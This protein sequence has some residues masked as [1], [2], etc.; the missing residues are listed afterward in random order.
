MRSWRKIRTAAS[1]CGFVALLAGIAVA[2]TN[3]TAYRASVEKWRAHR[4]ASLKSDD[5]WLTVA[6][7]FWL[8][9]G[10]NNFGTDALDDMVLPAGSAPAQAGTFEFHAGKT[11]VHANKAAQLMIQGKNADGA[12]LRADQDPK[13]DG[14]VDQVTLGVLTFYVH[15][16]G[17]RYAIRMQDKNNALRKR[18]TGLRW[19]PIDP[20]YRVEARYV[21]YDKPKVVQIQNMMGDFGP[22][23]IPG[24]VEFELHGQKLRLDVDIDGLELSIVF[25]DL[26]S[27]KETYGAAR[28]LVADAPKDGKAVLDFNEAYNPPCAYNPY[29]TCPL[30]TPANRLRVP[31]APGEMTYHGP[32]DP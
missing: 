2:A 29:T 15:Q 22:D 6:G 16:S 23:S 13:F 30:P 21:P 3:D 20:S 17:D 27:G 1:L 18:F 24:Y 5:G 32:H 14:K 12:A 7:L 8:H 4:Q 9:D 26:T 19:F 10:F 11:I 28:F 31:I 25:R